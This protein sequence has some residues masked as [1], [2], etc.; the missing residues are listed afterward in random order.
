MTKMV[1]G[2]GAAAKEKCGGVWKNGRGGKVETEGLWSI[3]LNGKDYPKQRV[4]EWC[5]INTE[6]CMG[7][8]GP[9][10]GFAY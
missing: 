2:S 4:S 7:I 6:Q 10:G 9:Y 3:F 8:W 1:K 5:G